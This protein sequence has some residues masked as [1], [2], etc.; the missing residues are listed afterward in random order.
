M[1]GV[2]AAGGGAI[3]A[4]GCACPPTPA[5]ACSERI[6]FQLGIARYTFWK[7]ELGKALG[8]MKEIDCHYLGLKEGSIRYDASDAEIAAYKANLAKYGVE[9]LSAGPDFAGDCPRWFVSDSQYGMDCFAGRALAES[10]AKDN[11]VAD[12][13]RGNIPSRAEIAR[14]AA[15]YLCGFNGLGGRAAWDETAVLIAVRGTE[16]YFNVHRGTYRMVGAD[17]ENSWSPDEENGPHLRVTEKVNKNEVAKV[18]DGLM[19]CGICGG[20]QKGASGSDPF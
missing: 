2:L 5:A 18:I 16:R 9:T 13:F 15:R 8:I 7:I 14:D 6:R 12:V 20:G 1:G 11:P 4:G 17:G 19:S 10:S 3:F